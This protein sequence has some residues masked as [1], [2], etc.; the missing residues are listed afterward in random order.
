MVER[1]GDV[2]EV[3]QWWLWELKKPP[4]R[5]VVEAHPAQGRVDSAAEAWSSR[6]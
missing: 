4:G 6:C 5:V 3:G 2:V 1:S